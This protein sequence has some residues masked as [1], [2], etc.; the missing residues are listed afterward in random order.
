LHLKYIEKWT[1]NG[2]VV[3]YI[4]LFVALCQYLI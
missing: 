1:Q 2:L 4:Q 3:S